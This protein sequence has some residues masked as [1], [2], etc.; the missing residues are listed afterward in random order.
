VL[1]FIKTN[2]IDVEK[3]SDLQKLGTYMQTIL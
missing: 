3:V 1:D 2:K